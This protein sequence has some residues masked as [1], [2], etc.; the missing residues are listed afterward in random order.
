[1]SPVAFRWPSHPAR[2]RRASLPR[3][4][5]AHSGKKLRSGNHAGWRGVRA[6]ERV[7]GQGGGN[8]AVQAGK[9]TRGPRHNQP[10]ERA[11]GRAAAGWVRRAVGWPPARGNIHIAACAS[12]CHAPSAR[13][14]EIR[15]GGLAGGRVVSGCSGG[16][17]GERAG[18][19][20]GGRAIGRPNVLDPV[21]RVS[22]IV[23]RAS[24]GA[25]G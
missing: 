7:A 3:C 2:S 23:A 1:M 21:A 24:H 18:E 25:K 5:R 15:R 12:A 4:E 10:G 22:N 8:A 9:R 11:G 6:V 17:A 16:R 20:A 19:L 13:H 14:R